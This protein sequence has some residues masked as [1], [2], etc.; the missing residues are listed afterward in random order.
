MT[1]VDYGL[2]SDVARISLFGDDRRRRVM[3]R[4]GVRYEDVYFEK[5]TS[6]SRESVKFWAGITCEDIYS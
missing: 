1:P 6:Y 4:P 3:R 2:F 5:I